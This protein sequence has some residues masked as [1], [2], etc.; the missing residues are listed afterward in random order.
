MEGLIMIWI[1]VMPD[2][3]LNC[4]MKYVM[5]DGRLGYAIQFLYLM[6]GYIMLWIIV[7]PD[8]RL[9]Y[10]MK[11][12]MPGGRLN[13]AMNYW[14]AW[15]KVILCSELLLGLM[16]GSIMLWMIVMPKGSLNNVMNCCYLD[17][18]MNY[19]YAWRKVRLCNELLLCMMESKMI[20]DWKV[21]WC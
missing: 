12:C 14:Y 20:L 2:E 6:E 13:Y 11:C 18:A 21:R 4:A 9:D 3:R 7:R 10:D 15:W 1:I 16:E 5:A 19:W 8:G 17:Y